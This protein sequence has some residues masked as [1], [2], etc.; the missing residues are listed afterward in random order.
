M[1]HAAAVGG[2]ASGLFA[3]ARCNSAAFIE[4][5]RIRIEQY[6]LALLA[7]KEEIR[8]PGFVPNDVHIHAVATLACN[9]PQNIRDTY[10]PLPVSPLGML[11]G[12]FGFGKFR[13]T[14]AHVDAVYDIV[15]LKGGIDAI[16]MPALADIME[17][18]ATY[19]RFGTH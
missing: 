10:E 3:A 15:R 7:L 5:D 17:R 4:L 6:Q 2:A 16:D 12:V 1:Y 18:S 9:D 13:L 19:H 8:R 14:K 11:Q